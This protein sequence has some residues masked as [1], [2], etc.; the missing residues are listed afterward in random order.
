MTL[1]ASAID[2]M[3]PGQRLK[4]DRVQGLEV[5]KHPT[6]TSFLLYYRTRFGVARRPKIGNYPT[7]SL[8][9]ARDIARGMLGEV[10]AGRDPS[11]ESRAIRAE[12]T[13][14]DLWAKCA[15]EHW[16][17]AKQWDG[18]A[19]SLYTRYLK[20]KM[21]KT[22]VASVGYSDIQGVHASLAKTANT[23]NRLLAVASKMLNLA[24]RWEWRPLGTN[25]CQHV[26]RFPEKKR[27]RYAP[28]DEIGAIGKALAKIS[29][30][31]GNESGAA[32]LYALMFSGARPSEIGRAKPDMLETRGDNTVLRI[33]DGKTGHR[34]VYLPAQAT[35]VFAR[36]PKDRKNL[37][38]R[39]TV[40]RALWKRVLKEA[41]IKGLWARDL[42]RTF[43]TIALSEGLLTLDQLGEL[44]G[45]KSRQTTMVYAKLLED[46]A[47]TGSAKVAGHIEGLL[48]GG[49]PA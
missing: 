41:G 15:A 11:A 2:A 32:F 47:H 22:K 18:E 30:E 44:L 39:V 9:Q 13:M 26:Q 16:N 28:P 23:A 20:P 43:G 7:I 10:A 3:A 36:L 1:T 33:P 14:D 40:P 27:K 34:D 17:K 35:R 25:P 38:G 5:R 49:P 42:R 8:A 6:G 24:E 12:P 4:D 37:A 31:P 29:E 46:Q 48:T 19:L 21:G 45:H